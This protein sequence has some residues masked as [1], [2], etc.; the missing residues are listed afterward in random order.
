MTDKFYIG[1]EDLLADS[2][3]LAHQVHQSGF[4]PTFIMALWRGGA[5]IGLAVQEYF[6]YHNIDTDHILVRTSSYHGID[7]QSRNVIIHG[8]SYLVKNLTAEDRVLIVDDVFDTGQT[9]N[10]IVET[11]EAQLK[12]NMPQDIRVAVPYFKPSRNKTDRL[13]E[14]FLHETDEWLVYP[15][16]VEGLTAEEIK[17]HKPD[18]YQVLGRHLHS[19]KR[20]S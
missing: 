5:P 8:F 9:I 11:M 6:A 3:R 7:Q 1:A 20:Q 18:L 15:H 4:E 13:P 17:T 19:P 2:F 12:L 14:Y 16:S 10:A